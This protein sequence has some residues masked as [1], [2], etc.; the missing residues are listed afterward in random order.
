MNRHFASLFLPS[1]H[2]WWASGCRSFWRVSHTNLVIICIKTKRD[3]R[4]I[5]PGNSSI[6]AAIIAVLADTVR[7][8]LD[9]FYETK[10][11][12]IFDSFGTS[13]S[14]L[15]SRVE[16]NANNDFNLRV[17]GKMVS[18]RT[19]PPSTLATNNLNR[20]RQWMTHP[21]FFAVRSRKCRSSGS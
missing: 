3:H 18:L 2:G 17:A 10:I 20:R 5:T 14:R 6:P 4:D 1:H 16:E 21:C 11:S 13:L 15:E 8:A 9:T 12:P 19:S 7:D